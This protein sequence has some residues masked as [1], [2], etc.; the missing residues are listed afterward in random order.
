MINKYDGIKLLFL[1]KKTN[2]DDQYDGD[3]RVVGM[4]IVP[5]LGV[6]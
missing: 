4:C 6:K 5:E 3:D 1:K 2:R